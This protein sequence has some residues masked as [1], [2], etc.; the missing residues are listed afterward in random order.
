MFSGGI[1]KNQWD[2]IGYYALKLFWIRLIALSA[3]AQWLQMFLIRDATQLLDKTMK[4]FYRLSAKYSKRLLSS[5]FKNRQFA[6]HLWLSYFRIIHLV[7]THNFLKFSTYVC[8]S[9][10]KNVSFSENFACVLNRWSL[11]GN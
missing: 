8:V 9:G 4:H 3:N 11:G 10:G 1:E 5:G 7:C 6:E 2:E